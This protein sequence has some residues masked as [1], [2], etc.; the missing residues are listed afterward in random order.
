MLRLLPI[1]HPFS[2]DP[3]K[4]SVPERDAAILAASQAKP[5]SY[6]LQGFRDPGKVK[7]LAFGCQGSGD[8]N[9]Y[10]VAKAILEYIDGNPNNTPDFIL[11]LGDNIYPEGAKSPRSKKFDASFQEPYAELIK[12]NI[13]FFVIT[14][15]HDYNMRDE[16]YYLPLLKRG[17]QRVQAEIAY[18]YLGDAKTTCD[19]KK[20]LFRQNKLP[21]QNC[22]AW[23]MP[24][25]YYTLDAGDTRI[26]CLDSST[27]IEDYL[28][29]EKSG[30]T[31]LNNQALWLSRVRDT[32]KKCIL[33][34]HH[35]IYSPGRRAFKKDVHLYLTKE[36]RQALRV[37]FPDP[38]KQTTPYNTYLAA[39]L[40]AQNLKFDL[41]I[42][43]HD[44][45][46][47]YY[48]NGDT[49]QLTLGGGGGVLQNRFEFNEQNNMGCFIKNFG[50]GSIQ[51][52]QHPEKTIKFSIHTTS[53][54]HLLFSVDRVTPRLKS[55][56]DSVSN[57]KTAVNLA[58]TNYFDF[59]AQKQN[60]DRTRFIEWNKSHGHH[61]I[62][63]VHEA[64]TLINEDRSYS[65]DDLARKLQCIIAKTCATSDHAFKGY[66]E[67]AL[68]NN[69]EFDDL[70]ESLLE[71]KKSDCAL[72]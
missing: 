12:R 41:I 33:A 20:E 11:L 16:S 25:R 29:K 71:K 52:K 58:I 51:L 69:S 30:Q 21:L 72:Q 7:F 22:P 40:K 27:Y 56:N 47:Y 55:K 64:W 10:D 19:Q 24:A 34:L 48:N 38:D 57:F 4:A 23:N 59:V 37:L 49:K 70:K 31:E 68:T 61:D 60:Q 13:P 1:A 44:H 15:N 54:Q 39:C 5:M 18:S 46:L 3:K 45:H 6:E 26:I 43:A 9:Q 62:N 35:P 36:Q 65:L 53:N 2:P 66:L 50:F 42:S 63:L 28:N 17:Y 67:A 8:H 14:G 32:D